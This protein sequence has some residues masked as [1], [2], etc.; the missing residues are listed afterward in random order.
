M[1]PPRVKSV[2]RLGFSSAWRPSAAVV[3]V[4]LT[5]NPVQAEY[6]VVAKVR[7]E[8]AVAFRDP[9]GIGVP[10]MV[11]VFNYTVLSAPA[12]EGT[13]ATTTRLLETA[14]LKVHWVR[15]T[16]GKASPRQCFGPSP[17]GS[18][19]LR[20]VPPPRDGD[21]HALSRRMTLGLAAVDE[22]G[23]GFIANVYIP[24]KSRFAGVTLMPSETLA[25]LVAA[26]ELAH[27]MLGNADHTESGLMRAEWSVG[28]L[29]PGRES[30]WRFSPI[31]GARLRQ[32][33][34]RL[35]LRELFSSLR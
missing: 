9:G 17:A 27:L 7:T 22:Q 1:S 32:A 29:T 19:D 25:G 33:A 16:S 6:T 13:I 2:L 21:S 34:R 28:E 3:A 23:F 26:H 20:L 12:I 11:R 5:G 4:L 31:E 10:L 35:V 15:C 14:D 24:E 18:L 30:S 8:G